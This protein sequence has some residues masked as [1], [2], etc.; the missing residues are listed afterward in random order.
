MYAALFALWIIFNGRFTPEV[1]VIGLIVSAVI[2]LFICRFMDYSI[3]K[4]KM[5]YILIPWMLKYFMILLAE[6]V[7]ANIKTASIILNPKMVPEPKIV[8]FK[9]DIRYGFLKVVLANSI[10]LTPGT[11][12]INVEDGLYTVHCL[13]ME[14]ASDIGDSVFVRE[15]L[16]AQDRLDRV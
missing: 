7:K 10:T 9:P 2:F 4:E 1:A 11:I 14:L 12:T 16:K 8:T 13:D 3:R 15:I 6:I 5:F